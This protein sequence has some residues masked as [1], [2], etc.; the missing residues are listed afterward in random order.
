MGSLTAE[1][2][3]ILQGGDISATSPSRIPAFTWYGEKCPTSYGSVVIENGQRYLEVAADGGTTEML[4][5]R[6]AFLDDIRFL[7]VVP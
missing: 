7:P 6:V 3:S 2:I 1:A 5:E 4:L